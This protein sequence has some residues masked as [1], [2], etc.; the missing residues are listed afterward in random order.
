VKS[1]AKTL[2]I[3]EY[4]FN[5]NGAPATPGE[6]AE[7]IEINA[8]TCSRIIGELAGRGYIERVSRR[9]GYIPGPVLYALNLR[10][11]PYGNIAAAAKEP[12][13][14]LAGE[15]STI[16][17]IAVMKNA[18]R[19]MLY[20][21]TA[22]PNKKFGLW[23]EYFTDH[24]STA[25]GRLLLSVA[26]PEEIDFVIKKLG[27]PKGEWNGIKTKD[28]LLKELAGIA[29]SGFVK[30][31]QNDIW[32]VGRIF[33]APGYPHAAIGFGVETEEKADLAL[34]LLEKTVSDIERNL[35]LNNEEKLSFY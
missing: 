23:T 17:N 15:L 12:I 8:A 2:D 35:S 3:L 14:K 1:L 16:I 29:K 20:F 10:R 11:S 6:V 26:S 25:T 13:K 24:Y 22:D 33:K 4:I 28:A 18:Y 19:Y 5:K 9:S 21:Y 27:L 32:V 30:Y 7:N 34:S 31:P